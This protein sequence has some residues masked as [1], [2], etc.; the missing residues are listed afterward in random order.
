M[1]FVFILCVFPCETI[2]RLSCVLYLLTV[3]KAESSFGASPAGVE[4]IRAVSLCS[5][6]FRFV[7][8]YS[9]SFCVSSCVPFCVPLMRLALRS[10]RRFVLRFLSL[11]SPLRL[12]IS[13]R[14]P[15]LPV[16]DSV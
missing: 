9:V 10:A 3:E 8:L 13:F 6:L 16:G 5:P 14:F 4:Y 12:V 1:V 11:V 7:F 2:V 15:C